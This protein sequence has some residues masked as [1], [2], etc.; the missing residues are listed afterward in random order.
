VESAAKCV[1]RAGKRFTFPACNAPVQH[2]P[3]RR[4]RNPY[5]EVCR[6]IAVVKRRA[7]NE[8]EI[9]SAVA[10]YYQIPFGAIDENNP[11]VIE[12][13]SALDRT[14]ASVALKL[15]NLASLDPTVLASGRHGMANASRLDR[16][17][18]ESTSGNWLE[19]ATVLPTTVVDAIDRNRH[20]PLGTVFI[21][22]PG[23]NPTEVPGTVML[24]RGQRFFRNST[25]AA[26]RERCCVTTLP[27]RELLR[28]SHIIPWAV[29]A[30]LRLDP[31]NGVCLNALY[32]AA[33]DRGLM[34]IDD[35]YRVVFARG[36]RDSV[37]HEIWNVWF[38]GYEGRRIELPERLVPRPSALLFHRQNVFNE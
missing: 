3:S 31:T 22:A 7:W 38:A 29:D 11:A 5:L 27:V 16:I 36:L 8:N 24:R 6:T 21:E 26:Y 20:Q 12:L 18:F 10:L 28:A 14:P 17:V 15:A 25:L 1:A 35:Q 34:T 33:F 13:A 30:S 2:A 32:D 4:L 37:T 23:S 9:V 19:L